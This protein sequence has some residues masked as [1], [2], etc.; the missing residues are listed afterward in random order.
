MHFGVA[1][2]VRQVQGKKLER[3]YAH[4]HKARENLD[5]L[6]QYEGRIY[7]SPMFTKEIMDNH[8]Y[9]VINV[10][11]GNY[12]RRSGNKTDAFRP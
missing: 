1:T 6:L 8:G 3:W 10:E 5:K 11:E 7:S 2:N 4:S 12:M 9:N